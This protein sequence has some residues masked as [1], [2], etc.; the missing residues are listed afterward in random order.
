MKKV[1]L[2][3]ITLFF[4]ILLTGCTDE[5]NELEELKKLESELKLINKDE[6]QNPRDKT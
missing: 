6:I 4:T 1:T 2:I 3:L 5:A